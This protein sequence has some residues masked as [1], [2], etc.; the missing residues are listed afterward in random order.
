[1]EVNM[2]R[3]FIIFRAT[4]IKINKRSKINYLKKIPFSCKVVDGEEKEIFY[5]S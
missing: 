2:I 4:Q 3:Y 1:M 5:I